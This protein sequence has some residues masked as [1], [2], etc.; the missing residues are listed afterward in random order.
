MLLYCSGNGKFFSFKAAH[1]YGEYFK[2][3]SMVVVQTWF[4]CVLMAS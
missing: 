2:L 1:F 3:L 4:L